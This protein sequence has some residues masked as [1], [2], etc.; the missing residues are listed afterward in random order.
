MATPQWPRAAFLEF[1]PVAEQV[2]PYEDI[3]SYI[4]RYGNSEGYKS[5]AVLEAVADNDPDALHTL[6]IR[7]DQVFHVFFSGGMTDDKFTSFF[8]YLGLYYDMEKDGPSWKEVIATI[9]ENYDW[10]PQ[11]HSTLLKGYPRRQK[12]PVRPL[13]QA[14]ILG[15][16]AVQVQAT[17]PRPQ[18]TSENYDRFTYKSKDADGREYSIEAANVAEAIQFDTNHMDKERDNIREQRDNDSNRLDKER[19]NIRAKGEEERNTIR[20]KGEQDRAIAKL[21]LLSAM[22]QSGQKIPRQLLQDDDEDTGFENL[23]TG[24]PCSTGKKKSN[25]KAR[26]MP[27]GGPCQFEEI[28]C[29]FDHFPTQEEICSVLGSSCTRNFT[30][31]HCKWN[32]AANYRSRQLVC[33]CKP[34]QSALCYTI[35]VVHVFATGKYHVQPARSEKHS[36]HSS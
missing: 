16:D 20:A 6:A 15:D 17:R 11:Q 10:F 33:S 4:D 3:I 22:V 32:A 1:Y 31:K 28:G 18:L 27:L 19:S 36:H 23:L 2:M 12:L 13:V 8:Y 35:R 34:K 14:T 26:D 5:H 30:A 25:R 24:A 29:T 21:Q 9:D 7:I